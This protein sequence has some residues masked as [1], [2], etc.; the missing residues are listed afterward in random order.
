MTGVL[1]STR[2]TD[3]IT[4]VVGQPKKSKRTKNEIKRQ[5]PFAAWLR[6]L[7]LFASK[8]TCKTRFLRFCRKYRGFICSRP[9][10]KSS[11]LNQ[12][13]IGSERNAVERAPSTPLLILDS[14]FAFL[15]FFG[16]LGTTKCC[17]AVQGIKKDKT[18]DK[19]AG[20]FCRMASGPA[21]FCLKNHLQNP[22]LEILQEIPCIFRV[23]LEQKI[24]GIL[25][26]AS[27]TQWSERP[28]LPC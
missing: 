21:S 7:P 20:P 6:G 13:S 28:P 23:I 25:S 14:S 22:L 15:D 3:C 2:S 24:I 4:N 19:M 9:E 26:E 10:R 12:K 27:G 1:S 17:R 18:R 8:I 5:A 11:E 16:C